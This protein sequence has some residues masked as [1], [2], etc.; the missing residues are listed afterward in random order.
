[1]ATIVVGTAEL[2]VQKQFGE[3]LSRIY[4]EE[5]IRRGY[6]FTYSIRTYGC[7]LNES[8]SEKMSGILCSLAFVP[9]HSDNPDIVI[10]NTCSI[11][12]N[13]R[14]RLFGNLGLVKEMK[15]R[16]PS[17]IVAVCGCMMKQR[18]NI[19]KIQKSYPFVDLIF[20]PQ[21][22]HRLPELIHRLRFEEKKVCD[23]SDTDYM[24]DDMDLPINRSRTFRALVPIMFGCNNFCTYCVVPYT[25][26]RERSRPFDL[27]M[28]EIS[29][30]ALGGYKEIL[31]LGQNVNS[32]GR[33]LKDAPDFAD[34]LEAV[35]NTKNL[36]RVRYMT[37]H[38]KDLSDHLIDI[39]AKYPVIEKHLHLP[40]QSGSDRILEA[41]NRHYTKEQYLHTARLFRERIPHGTIT[42]DIIVGFPGENEEDFQETLNVMQE[43]RFDSAFTFQYSVRPGTPA[44][45]MDDQIS[46]EVVTERFSRLLDLQNSHSYESNLLAVG[47]TE[48]I[49]IEGSSATASHILTGRTNNNRLVN[50]TLPDRSI[51]PDG[52]LLEN[53]MHVDG[54]KLEGSLAYV[55]ITGARPYSLEGQLENFIY[56]Q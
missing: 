56:D 10:Y 1:M 21:D 48:E 24:A 14:D 50:F 34:L 51:L 28:K 3:H 16:N 35:A 43:V 15:K 44:A 22:I 46:K 54:D 25:R 29:D 19:D 11:R 33:D 45:D 37:S 40:L 9:D 47:E 27:I 49:L 53:G 4:K 31:L 32:Y 8:D 23:V 20:G 30:L 18:E 42:T 6:D 13:A 41:M 52:S 38:P 2:A 26:G 7:Q 36:S 17:L 39:V 12:E 5:A 55:K